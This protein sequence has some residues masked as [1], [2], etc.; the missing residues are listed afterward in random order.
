MWR[1]FTS[2]WIGKERDQVSD[3]GLGYNIHRP[4]PTAS[5]LPAKPHLLLA[6]Q[7]FQI[8]PPPGEQAFGTGACVGNF[9]F[10]SQQYLHL[11]SRNFMIDDKNTC[12]TE[13]RGSIL[14]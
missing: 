2:L 12:K 4:I 14:E 13:Q 11:F 10:Q 6:P 7:P 8:I 3:W 1:L 5:L 9:R